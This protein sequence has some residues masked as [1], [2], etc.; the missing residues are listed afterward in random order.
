M[1]TNHIESMGLFLHAA[2]KEDGKALLTM[3]SIPL[4]LSALIQ[5]DISLCQLVNLL[6]SYFT[7]TLVGVNSA[8]VNVAATT[9][10]SHTT[11]S[12]TNSTNDTDGT[13]ASMTNTFSVHTSSYGEGN[14]GLGGGY[15]R[16]RYKTAS[17]GRNVAEE[18]IA[19][20]LAIARANKEVLL[21]ILRDYSDIL[22]NINPH[23]YYSV[24]IIDRIESYRKELYA[25]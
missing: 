6:N 15:T 7:I 16:I 21:R 9:S 25:R 17:F 20:I 1:I 24:E 11:S 18:K 19:H 4:I 22:A 10:S 2:L 8:V 13:T 12:H 5:F 14:N 3:H 23:E